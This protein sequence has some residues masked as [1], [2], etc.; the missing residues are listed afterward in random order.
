V[1]K[2]LLFV[3]VLLG[4]TACQNYSSN[5]GEMLGCT[6]AG[7]GCDDGR[8]GA[9]GLTGLPGSDGSNGSSCSVQTVLASEAAPAGGARISCTDGSDALLLNGTNGEDGSDAPATPYTITQVIKPCST[10][11]G[12]NPEVLLVLANRTILASVSQSAGANT[13]LALVT[14]GTYQTTDGRACVFTVGS[15]TVSWAGGSVGY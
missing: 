4:A 14:P 1:F 8:T 6:L 9:Q 2:S 11:S 13:R 7:N 3:G 5:V 10:V 12:A 15:S